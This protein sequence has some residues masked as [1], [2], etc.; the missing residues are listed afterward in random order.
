MT[1]HDDAAWI[2][3]MLQIVRNLNDDMKDVSFEVYF[4]NSVA[5]SAILYN[6]VVLGQASVEV[7]VQFRKQFNNI[8]W[9]DLK[10]LGRTRS[11]NIGISIT[12]VYGNS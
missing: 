7:S 1:H 9:N 12:S 6:F 3:D 4:H 5:Q 2:V 10:V 8:P 11:M